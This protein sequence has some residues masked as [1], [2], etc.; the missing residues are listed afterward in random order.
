MRS[1]KRWTVKHSVKWP[2]RWLAYQT[3]GDRIIRGSGTTFRTWDAAMAYVDS[4]IR[5]MQR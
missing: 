4:K 1:Q 5:W 3:Y 2:G